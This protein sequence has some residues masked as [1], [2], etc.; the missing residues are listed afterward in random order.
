MRCCRHKDG[1]LTLPVAD[2]VFLFACRCCHADSL[3]LH[4][5]AEDVTTGGLVFAPTILDRIP[6]R[7][8]ATAPPALLQC[9][10]PA[11]SCGRLIHAGLCCALRC[12]VKHAHKLRPEA[13][14]LS[15]L[16]SHQRFE[17]GSIPS[18]L[19]IPKLCSKLNNR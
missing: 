13:G 5:V 16:V 14:L 11:V 10:L 9:H 6:H 17:A 8:V 3:Q 19:T 1:R 12:V 7:F 18:F 4:L 2:A 15:L